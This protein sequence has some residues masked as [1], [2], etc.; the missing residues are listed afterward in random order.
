[1]LRPAHPAKADACICHLAPLLAD[2]FALFLLERAQE[3]IKVPVGLSGGI[4]AR[5]VKLN[6]VAHHQ[7]GGLASLD[8]AGRQEQQVQGRQIFGAG[9]GHQRLDQGSSSVCRHARASARRA[10][11]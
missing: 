3:V 7:A 8:V 1:M 2:F 9:M 4:L 6:R 5:P 10:R 11:V